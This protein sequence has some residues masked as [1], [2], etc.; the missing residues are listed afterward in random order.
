MGLFRDIPGGPVDYIEVYTGSYLAGY[1]AV[2]SPSG[3]AVREPVLQLLLVNM[4]LA[5]DNGQALVAAWYSRVW[6]TVLE[7][8]PGVVLMLLRPDVSKEIAA[9]RASR[10]SAPN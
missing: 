10:I 9:A 2:F 4:Q 1:V 5:A 8:L 6:L 7:I 3:I